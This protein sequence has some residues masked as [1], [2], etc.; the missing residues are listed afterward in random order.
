MSQ[1]SSNVPSMQPVPSATEL[2][3]RAQAL[4]PALLERAT[5]AE[6]ARKMLPETITDFRSA[7]FYRIVQPRCYGG[8]ELDFDTLFR[9]VVEVGSACPSSSWCLC[10]LSL[11]N[12]FVGW[13]PRQAQ[14]TVFAGDE[15]PLTAI[16]LAPRGKAEKVD[17]GYKVNGTWEYAS[18]VEESNFVGVAGVVTGLSEGQESP[19]VTVLIPTEQIEILDNWFTLGL[20][21][22]GSKS[23]VCKDVFVPDHMGCVLAHCQDGSPGKEVHDNPLYQGFA[24]VPLF[25]MGGTAPALGAA[26]LMLDSYIKRLQTHSSPFLRSDHSQLIP[27]QVRL[28]RASTLY[29]SAHT[30]FFSAVNEYFDI[31]NARVELTLEQRTRYRS[32]SAQVLDFCVQIVDLIMADAGTG[33]FF[34]G[35]PMQ[36]AFRDV[37]MLQ[38]HV[39]MSLESAAENYGKVQ[40]GFDPV[41]PM[42]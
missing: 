3:A 37:H 19:P 38:S 15:H 36:R 39:A 10:L 14:E 20:R 31:V 6:Q 40:L 29:E 8:Y 9:V 32:Q 28:G 22:T 4:K 25:A 13:W 12:W 1:T 33:A 17:G 2:I 34:D 16:V 11:H 23:V 24:R 41:P 7:G 21:G 18:G 35:S 5:R 27:S 26:R 30:L 42:V